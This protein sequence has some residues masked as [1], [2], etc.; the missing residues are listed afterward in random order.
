MDDASNRISRF[1]F[2][3]LVVNI[4]YG[5]PVAIGLFFIGIPNAIL[6]GVLGA[7]MRFVPYIGV[8]I[9]AV[10]PI[11]LSFAVST[12]W[13]FPILTISLYICLELLIANFVEPYLIG[14]YTGVSPVALIIAAVFWTWLWGPI[15]LLLSTPL[16][17]CLVVMGQHVPSLG[18][19][20][21]LLSDI[22][23]LTPDQELYH[24]L[25]VSEQ[26][27]ALSL[28]E[29]YLKT[30]SLIEVYDN[31]LIPVILAGE[32]DL[33]L[34]II[35]ADQGDAFHQ[36]LREIIEDLHGRTQTA[37]AT[38]QSAEQ[39]SPLPTCTV[40]C[41]PARAERDELVGL[42]FSQVLKQKF[43]EAENVSVKISIG[44]LIEG[45]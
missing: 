29:S 33:S 32:S 14:S 15:G 11:A 21:V 12:G 44:E 9:A 1:L 31:V 34:G 3:Q 10:I 26:N 5:I 18:F 38:D 39:Q 4:M 37:A 13:I 7:L 20:S 6:W 17:V 22:K 16:T 19:L 8:W 2:M 45:F 30:H 25:L 43:Y 23:A 36:N 35:D 40:V 24:R 28:V 27:E 42:M 41:V